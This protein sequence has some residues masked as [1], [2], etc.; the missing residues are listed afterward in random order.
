MK[1]KRE[2]AKT[3]YDEKNPTISI[4]ISLEEYE[5]LN[6][7]REDGLSFKDIILRGAGLIERDRATEAERIEAV[8]ASIRKCPLGNAGTA[9]IRFIG[10]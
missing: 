6:G 2:N 10:T 3:R 8:R 7:L 5:H 9:A 4:R 1:P